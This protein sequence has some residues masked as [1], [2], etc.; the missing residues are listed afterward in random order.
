MSRVLRFLRSHQSAQ[1]YF[2]APSALLVGWECTLL[3]VTFCV[4]HYSRA[5]PPQFALSLGTTT[6][7]DVTMMAQTRRARLNQLNHRDFI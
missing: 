5:L 7:H 1:F 3:L 2:T 4:T 6:L